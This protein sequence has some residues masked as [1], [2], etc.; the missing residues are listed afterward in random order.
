MQFLNSR[1]T[2]LWSVL[3]AVTLPTAACSSDANPDVARAA[4]LPNALSVTQNVQMEGVRARRDDSALSAEL[5]RSLPASPDLDVVGAVPIP[6]LAWTDCGDGFQCATAAVPRD[7]SRPRGPTTNLAVTRLPARNASQRIGSLFVNFGGPGGT[8]VDTLHAFGALLFE[9]L[10]E[11]FDIVGFDPRGVGQS[12]SPIDCQ[13][14]QETQGIYAQ[15]FTTPQRLQGFV[16]RARN[17][18]DACVRN[19]SETTLR[20]ASTAN[21]ARDMDALRAAVGDAKLSYLGFSF[22][23]F[24]GATYASLFPGNYR[25][26]VLDGALDADQYIN[27]P[28]EH[29]L[30]QTSGFE[31]ALDRFFEACA[32]NQTACVGFGGSDPHAAFDD[33]VARADAAPIPATGDDPRPIDGDDIIWVAGNA[34]YAKQLWPALARALVAARDGDGTLVRQRANNSYGRNPDGSYDPGLD[35]Y[36]ALSAVEQRYPSS[37]V[38]TYLGAGQ[39]AWEMFDHAFWNSGY[40]ELPIGLFPIHAQGVFRGPFRAST[41]APAILVI[42]TTYDPATPYREAI[43]LATQLRNARL[44]TMQGDGHTAYGG[45]SACIDAAVDAYLNQGTVPAAG[46]ACQ[47]EV[48]FEQLQLQARAAEARRAALSALRADPAFVRALR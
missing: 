31:R 44:L 48:P 37:D 16:A 11:R 1:R 21:V 15:P 25:A 41:S 2:S 22:G 28:S 36:F 47:Q 34:I 9:S 4:S 40:S 5:D 29:L 38:E 33:L 42:G 7:Y 6:A 17:F 18:V 3:A 20:F 13:V 46:A 19:N 24:L 32:A 39:A 43:R 35:R 26:L 14:N 45:N 10:N 30:V 27:R 8:A 12:E 23:T